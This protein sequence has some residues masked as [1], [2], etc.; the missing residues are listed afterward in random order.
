M[1]QVIALLGKYGVQAI[2]QLPVEKYIE[3]A[4]EIRA[5]G[6]QI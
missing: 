4:A 6:G 5:I 2:N 1:G 3:F